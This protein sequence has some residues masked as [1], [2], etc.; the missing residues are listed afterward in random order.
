M[1]KRRKRTVRG[2]ISRVKTLEVVGLLLMLG[3]WAANWNLKKQEYVLGGVSEAITAIDRAYIYE[4]LWHKTQ[5]E[6][7][8]IR[9]TRDVP[10]PPDFINPTKNYEIAWS[11]SPEVRLRWIHS[12]R[13]VLQQIEHLLRVMRRMEAEHDLG[14]SQDVRQVEASLSGTRAHLKPRLI[15][16][17]SGLE[18]PSDC[19]PGQTASHNPSCLTA[20]DASEVERAIEGERNKMTTIFGAAVDSFQERQVDSTTTYIV[21]FVLG[22]L[23]FVL[24]KVLELRES[25]RPSL[26]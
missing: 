24:A 10:G 22:S 13:S 15:E 4:S 2:S 6:G 18:L 3:S 12:Q 17:P 21:V 14:L 20:F 8:V 26:S 25:Y 9:A 5:L 16:L 11:L 7:A 23:L 1:P 19:A